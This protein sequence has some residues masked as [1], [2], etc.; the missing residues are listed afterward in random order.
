MPLL[1]SAYF[2]PDTVTCLFSNLIDSKKAMCQGLERW[3]C[4]LSCLPYRHK[5]IF[6]ILRAY[7]KKKKNNKIKT[8]LHIMPVL[9]RQ[10]QASLWGLVAR[11]PILFYKLRVNETPSRKGGQCLKNDTERYSLTSPYMPHTCADT[12]THI[13]AFP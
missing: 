12:P 8:M 1:L 11:Q 4:W 6:S 2:G 9:G 3:L 5:G 10:S 13:C 7:I